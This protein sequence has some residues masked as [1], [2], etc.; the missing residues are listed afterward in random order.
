MRWAERFLIFFFCWQKNA[1]KDC[2]LCEFFF[3]KIWLLE[4]IRFSILFSLNSIFFHSFSSWKKKFTGLKLFRSLFLFKTVLRGFLP[5]LIHFFLG[6]GT[7]PWKMTTAESMNVCV[8]VNE[9]ECV[10]SVCCSPLPREPKK[11]YC[12][13]CLWIKLKL[14]QLKKNCELPKKIM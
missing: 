10:C 13:F 7:K 3:D 11:N 5:R 2:S 4:R 1:W 9:K 6:R 8:C 14:K 12:E